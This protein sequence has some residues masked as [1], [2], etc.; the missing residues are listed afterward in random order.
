MSVIA[1][2]NRERV[3]LGFAGNFD[4]IAAVCML[5][6]VC[7]RLGNGQ[8]HV[9]DVFNREIQP[10]GDGCNGQAGDGDPLGLA[11]DPQF[12]DPQGSVGMSYRLIHTNAFI[13]DSSSS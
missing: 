4:L 11:G 10:I 13:A 7:T 3:R 1:N 9:L 8:F 6:A 12:D 2:A 5:Y